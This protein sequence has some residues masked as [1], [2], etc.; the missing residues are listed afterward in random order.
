[1]N[2]STVGNKALFLIWITCVILGASC[3]PADPQTLEEVLKAQTF[4][5]FGA[6]S[7]TNSS[8]RIGFRIARGRVYFNVKQIQGFADLRNGIPKYLICV[9]DDL[10]R[11]MIDAELRHQQEEPNRINVPLFFLRNER[12]RNL[13]MTDGRLEGIDEVGLQNIKLV[14]AKE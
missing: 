5:I 8:K 1:M 9:E 11:E 12:F 4:P 2:H 13:E 7:Y 3:K 10:V 14:R 6:E